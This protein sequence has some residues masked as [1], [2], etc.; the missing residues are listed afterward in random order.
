MAEEKDDNKDVV[1]DEGKGAETTKPKTKAEKTAE[2]KVK[3]EADLEKAKADAEQ[4]KVD[5]E[6]A[7]AEAKEIKAK[8]EQLEQ[9]N[10]FPKVLKVQ[11]NTPSKVYF[12]ELGAQDEDG[13][14]PYSEGVVI[15]RSQE[16]FA[17]FEAN[18]KRQASL[19]KWGS[20]PKK[21]RGVFI[22]PMD[23]EGAQ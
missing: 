9:A 13:I 3:L 14:L 15:I 21:D 8:A 19:G 18:L 16:I 5:A 12:A 4:A 22:I 6:V 20:D 1:T 2:E 23:K 10:T 17:L 11:N 7:R